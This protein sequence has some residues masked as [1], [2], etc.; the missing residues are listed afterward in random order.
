MIAADQ[1]QHPALF[2]ALVVNCY[3]GASSVRSLRLK[4]VAEERGLRRLRSARW[5]YRC[6][7]TLIFNSMLLCCAQR[8][9]SLWCQPFGHP[10]SSGVP[11]LARSD[12]E[13]YLDD[14]EVLQSR[15]HAAIGRGNRSLFNLTGLTLS[16]A[17]GCVFSAFALNPIQR[18]ARCRMPAS[19]PSRRFRHPR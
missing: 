14:A 13:T 15:Y 5:L 12:P 7:Q 8:R 10:S 3:R 4:I 18:R 11:A 16:G 1:A 19:S 2:V 9:S 6:C 17:K